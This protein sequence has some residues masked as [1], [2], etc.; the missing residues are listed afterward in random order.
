MDVQ[1]T[2]D[3]Q[4]FV[5]QAIA[6][7]RLNREED[8]IREA[9]SLWEERERTRVEILLGVDDAEAALARGEGRIITTDSMRELSMDVQ[10]RGEARL[11]AERS[12]Q[13]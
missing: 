4:E 13:K 2:P 8:A 3:Q 11:A 5:R 9:L 12:R 10:R 7:G 1:F 6:T